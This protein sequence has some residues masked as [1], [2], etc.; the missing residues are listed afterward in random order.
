MARLERGSGH[1]LYGVDRHIVAKSGPIS[2]PI[3]EDMEEHRLTHT[4]SC[5]IGKSD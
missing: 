4:E 1:V 5:I 2:E 3:S